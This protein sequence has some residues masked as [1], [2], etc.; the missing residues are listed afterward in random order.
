MFRSRFLLSVSGPA[1]IV[2]LLVQPMVRQTAD[3][4]AGSPAV[5]TM[6]PAPAPLP[7]MRP[8]SLAISPIHVAHATRIGERRAPETAQQTDEKAQLS[9]KPRRSVREGCETAVSSLAG[10]EARR[11]VPGR[12]IA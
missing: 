10:P 8:V 5:A 12:C 9:I 3:A 2:A 4:W 11:M 1:A 7:G 6:I